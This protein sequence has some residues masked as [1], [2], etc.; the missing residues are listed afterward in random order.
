MTGS[1]TLNLHVID[2]NDNLP[3]PVVDTVAMCLSDVPTT[4]NISTSDLDGE[5]FGGPFSYELLGDVAG[6]WRLDPAA[7]FS[8]GLVKEPDVY[9]GRHKVKL[10]IYDSKGVSAV[11]HIS[12]MVC[13]CS[14]SGSCLSRRA[15]GT[16]ASFS[17]VG[18]VIAA[19]LLPLGKKLSWSSHCGIQ[20]LSNLKHFLKFYS[21][22]VS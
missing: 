19:L 21:S 17:A 8:A 16:R 12:V 10:K 3:R 9:A 22:K 18:I 6:R 4:A 1:T 13:D 5:L 20:L 2:L 14:V 15:S 7:G 11:Y